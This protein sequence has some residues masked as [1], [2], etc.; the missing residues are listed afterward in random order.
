MPS[1]L[2]QLDDLADLAERHHCS[3]IYLL[4]HIRWDDADLQEESILEYGLERVVD[5]F[6]AFESRCQSIGIGVINEMMVANTPELSPGQSSSLKQR[7]KKLFGIHPPSTVGMPHCSQPW[8]ILLITSLGTVM[9]CTGVL[10]DRIYGDFRQ[11]SL[12][13]IWDSDEFQTLRA[14]LKDEGPACDHCLQCPHFSRDQSTEEVSY[15]SE[16]HLDASILA[17]AIPSIKAKA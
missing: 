7:I 2:D 14:G 10:V 1:N 13:Q 16:R 4:P 12:Q 6:A 9:P 3:E 5:Q 8:E 15:H 17:K 11:Q